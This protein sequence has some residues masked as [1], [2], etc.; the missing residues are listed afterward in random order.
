MAHEK[1]RRKYVELESYD[2]GCLRPGERLAGADEVGRGALAGPVVA[3]AVILPRASELVGVDD[4]KRLTEEERERLFPLI[5]GKAVAV[6]ISFSHPSVID[7]ENVL[8]A[9]L[10][11]LARAVENLRV[12]ADLVL[13]DGR[14]RI[15]IPGRI[16][17]VVGGD[18][19]SLSIAAASIVAKVT[20]DRL[21][22]KLHKLHP[23]YN[24]ISNKGY[25]TREH[26][27]AIQ[28]H[29]M[30]AVHRRSYCLSAVE[31]APSLF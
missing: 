13:L 17:P 19:M 26:L 24:F 14:D 22:R 15:D 11:A 28:R 8:N 9:S 20:R 12:P 10:M 30:T 2:D 25:G 21:M 29:G 7:R 23:V 18:R 6:G 27:D 1:R 5:L 3:A 4:S 16:V 31:N